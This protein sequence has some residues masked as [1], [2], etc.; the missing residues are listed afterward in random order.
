MAASQFCLEKRP[1]MVGYA[2]TLPVSL[3]GAGWLDGGS[4]VVVGI[5]IGTSMMHNT[6]FALLTAFSPFPTAYLQFLNV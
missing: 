1:T 2:C 3:S 4:V 6:L 5:P